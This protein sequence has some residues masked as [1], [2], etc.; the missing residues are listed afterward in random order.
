MGEAKAWAYMDK[1]NENIASYTHSGSKP[2]RQAGAGEYA[3]GISFE[4]TAAAQKTKGAPIEAILP[5]PGVGWD[6]EANAIIK[7][8]KKMEAAKK[9]MDFAATKKANELYNEYYAVV[10]YK[11]VNKPI[12]NYPANA[13]AQMIKTIDF[14]W[15]ANNRER[16]LA[17]WTKRYDSKSEPK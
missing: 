15:A 12:P 1:L 7:G 2:C 4:Y 16:I 9:L 3:L 6:M 17:E 10:A 14:E 13:E 5:K 11:G 8:T